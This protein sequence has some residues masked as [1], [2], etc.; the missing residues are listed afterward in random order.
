MGD[1][2]QQISATVNPFNA[3]DT[4]VSW[5]SSDD[6]IATVDQS[7]FV[8]PI[9]IGNATITVTTTDGGFEA[10]SIVTVIGPVIIPVTGITL[11]PSNATM[12]IGGG[13]LLLEATILPSNASNQ[14]VL[15]STSDSSVVNVNSSGEVVS[16]TVG[17]AVITATTADGGFVSTSTINVVETVTDLPWTEDF[18]DLADGAILD[19]GVTAWST[20]I[21]QGAWDVRG[22][23]LLLSSV[24]GG[25]T[26]VWS[27][28]RI[29]ITGY[30]NV[31]ISIDVDDL[32]ATKESNDYVNVYYKLDDGS[33][34]PIGTV[35]GNIDLTT[36]TVSGI[37][38]SVLELVVETQVSWSGE[39]YSIDNVNVSG[40]IG[41]QAFKTSISSFQDTP[42]DAYIIYPNPVS[43]VLNIRTRENNIVGL[44]QIFDVAGKLVRNYDKSLFNTGTTN[45]HIT[46]DGLQAGS[47]SLHIIDSQNNRCVKKLLV[48]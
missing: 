14:S 11:S 26:A 37:T 4:S 3:N 22:G 42:T 45:I 44:I 41:Q 29:A 35:T 15:W 19:T 24:N 25:S 32:D 46:L 21:D 39:T 30:E 9:A 47:Y 10:E 2:S 31:T 7:G 12:N 40:V 33:L 13:T 27:S 38:G 6:S 16:N 36:F 8:T 23:L 18:E 17:T 28:E 48:N 34:I 43:G 20:S 1:S 5:L